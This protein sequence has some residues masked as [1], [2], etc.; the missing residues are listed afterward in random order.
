M[1]MTVVR[2]QF[3]DDD[4]YVRA[5]SGQRAGGRV[6]GRCQVTMAQVGRRRAGAMQAGRDTGRKTVPR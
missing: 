2:E 5:I 6:M 4:D 3:R 1:T